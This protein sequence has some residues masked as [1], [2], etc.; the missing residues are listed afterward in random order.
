MLG[1]LTVA[2]RRLLESQPRLFEFTGATKQSEWNIARHFTN[3][4]ARLLPKY[5]SDA[6]THASYRKSQEQ[7]SGESGTIHSRTR[8]STIRL[9]M[10]MNSSVVTQP[11]LT[12]E[13]DELAVLRRV[14]GHIAGV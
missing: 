6:G 5:D 11:W 3:E 1:L 14:L 9:R 2:A 10:G 13:P 4:L 7:D 8:L 12:H